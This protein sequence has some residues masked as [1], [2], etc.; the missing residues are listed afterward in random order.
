MGDLQKRDDDSLVKRNDSG[1]SRTVYWIVAAVAFLMIGVL[2]VFLGPWL[3]AGAGILVGLWL[4]WRIF[5]WWT[6]DD[7]TGEQALLSDE[8]APEDELGSEIALEDLRKR[9]ESESKP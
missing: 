4:V 3:L 6:S 5:S 1:V 8:R 2:V 9:A 7:E